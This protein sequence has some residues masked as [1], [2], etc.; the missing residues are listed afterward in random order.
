M[1]RVRWLSFGVLALALLLP[2]CSGK[3]TKTPRYKVSG[4]LTSGGK[5][6]VMSPGKAPVAQPSV[7]MIQVIF[8]P[9][10]GGPRPDDPVKAGIQPIYGKVEEDGQ[11]TV[12]AGLPAGKYIVAVRQLDSGPQGP[13]ALNDK[14]SFKNSKII[15]EVSEDRVIDI[16]LNKYK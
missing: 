14:F 3:E 5:A 1:S 8:Y 16:E 2:G 13:D 15:E 6:L 10:P 9:M 12:H 7:G 11:Y 4:Q